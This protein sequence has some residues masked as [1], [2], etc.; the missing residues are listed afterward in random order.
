[1][2]SYILRRILYAVPIIF[3]VM[4]ITFALFFFLTTPE[5]I[6]RQILGDKAKKEVVD[7]W[8]S[9]KGLDK[10][11]F[12]NAEQKGFRKISDSLFY[13][14]MISLLTLNFGRSFQDDKPIGKEILSRAGPSLSYTIPIFITGLFFSIL[15]SLLFAYF[16]STYVDTYGTLICVLLMSIPIV[17]YILG[18]Q[19][20][21]SITWKLVPVSGWADGADRLRF[22]LL[23]VIIGVISGIGGST[24]F[25]RT[26]M[27]EETS[28]DYV[29]TAR[30]KGLSESLILFRHILKNAMIPILTNAVMAIPFLFM[31]SLLTE[32]FF[33]I[34]GLGSFAVDALF[35]NDLPSIKAIIYIGAILY[36]SGLIM[37]DISYALVDPR[38]VFE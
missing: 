14:H 35:S 8:I 25:Y 24:R 10:P 17:V 6:A 15:F 18:S 1:M 16:R 32:V 9:Q 3:G 30:S 23:P 20:L 22:I 29:R 11:Y 12:W 37:T 19:W 26:V 7:N 33:G 36:Q 34:P 13:N 31:G 28:K 38:V 27:V 2:K 21:L 4:L 5:S